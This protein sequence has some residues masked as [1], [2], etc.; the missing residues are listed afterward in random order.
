VAVDKAA[1]M[2]AE[3]KEYIEKRVSDNRVTVLQAD[4]T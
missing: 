3:A 4:C 2:V 1:E